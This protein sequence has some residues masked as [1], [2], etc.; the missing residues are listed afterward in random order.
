[1]LPFVGDMDAGVDPRLP[2]AV[3]SLGGWIRF[4]GYFAFQPALGKVVDT[5]LQPGQIRQS[6]NAGATGSTSNRTTG[7]PFRCRSAQERRSFDGSNL[8]SPTL[9]RVRHFI[10]TPP[11]P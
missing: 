9:R 8:I 2:G 3:F 4:G 10:S 11:F 5:G 6:G 7:R 1:L